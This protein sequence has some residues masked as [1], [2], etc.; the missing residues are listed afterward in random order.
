MTLLFKYFKEHGGIK[1]PV[2]SSVTI[3]A[4]LHTC[5]FY[6]YPIY[7]LNLVKHI[8]GGTGRSTYSFGET[9]ATTVGGSV[10]ELKGLC[11]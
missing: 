3:H 9:A 8:L 6:G 5:A 4:Y 10:R 2:N 7:V 11:H 1:E